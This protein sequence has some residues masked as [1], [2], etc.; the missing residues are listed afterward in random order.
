MGYKVLKLVM[1][2]SQGESRE[3]ASVYKITLRLFSINGN[4]KQKTKTQLKS[5]VVQSDLPAPT[6]SRSSCA[7]GVKRNFTAH[8]L[9]LSFCRPF[10]IPPVF[11]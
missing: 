1:F 6:R 11:C 5:S 10:V 9:D 8:S 7:T 4:P 2:L 3:C